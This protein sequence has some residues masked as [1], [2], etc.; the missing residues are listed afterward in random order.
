MTETIS[1]LS[2]VRGVMLEVP[3]HLLVERRRL[4][5]DRFDEMWEGVLHMVPPPDSAHQALSFRLASAVQ[6]RLDELGLVGLTEAG[7]F[8]PDVSDF[9]N[10]RQPDVVVAHPDHVSK[11]GV[12]GVAVLAVEIRSPNDETYEKL[13]FYGRVGVAELLVIDQ[14]RATIERFVNRDGRLLLTTADAEGWVP[15][16]GLGLR[17]RLVDDR[18]VI[19]AQR[20]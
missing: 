11:R 5:H 2:G 3:E 12:E 1:T 16:D 17:L 19:E 20:A 14:D 9:T 15:L 6:A 7:L 8:D 4:G 18:P 13:D 10:F